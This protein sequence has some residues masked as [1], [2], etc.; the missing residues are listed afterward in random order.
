MHGVTSTDPVDK[1]KLGPV[2]TSTVEVE[3]E[4][5]E[6]LLDTGSP[7]TIISWEWLLQLLAKKRQ[8]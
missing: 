8:E 1:V 2:L 6:A 4:P 7:M 3:S 5:V